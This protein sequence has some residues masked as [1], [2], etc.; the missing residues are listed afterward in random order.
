MRR[1]LLSTVKILIS[2]ALLYFAGLFLI[3]W[4]LGGFIPKARGVLALATTAACTSPAAR[5]NARSSRPDFSI[6]MG[7]RELFILRG[8]G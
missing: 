6:T 7:I 3:G 4:L 5:T 8:M 1:I 2:A